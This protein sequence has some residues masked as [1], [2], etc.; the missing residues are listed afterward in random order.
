MLYFA[1]GAASDCLDQQT[2]REGLAEWIDPREVKEISGLVQRG[3][4]SSPGE[5]VSEPPSGGSGARPP[6]GS[7]RGGSGRRPSAVQPGG[8]IPGDA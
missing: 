3:P 5:E 1:R 4:E 7:T 2:L 6:V 8:G